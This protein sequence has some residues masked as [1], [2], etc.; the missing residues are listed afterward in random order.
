MWLHLALLLGFC[1]GHE[2]NSRLVMAPQPGL[3]TLY[4]LP[5]D[6]NIYGGITIFPYTQFFSGFVATTGLTSFTIEIAHSPGAFYLDDISVTPRGVSPASNVV[7]NPGFENAALSPWV[8]NQ[9]GTYISNF[10]VHSGSS[11]YKNSINTDGYILTQTFNTVP[12]TTYDFNFWLLGETAN[13]GQLARV[14]IRTDNSFAA[15]PYTLSLSPSSDSGYSHTDSITNV[16]MPVIVG[17]SLPGSQVVFSLDGSLIADGG[18][19]AAADGTFLYTLPH[20]NPGEN[21]VE[22]AVTQAYVV[23]PLSLKITYLPP[24]PINLLLDPSTDSG[25]IGDGITS[26]TTILL[27]GTTGRSTVVSLSDG[28]AIVSSTTSDPIT[29]QFSLSVLVTVGVHNFLASGSDDAG[30]SPSMNSPLVVTIIGTTSS[31]SSSTTSYTSS[32]SST[33]SSTS[34]TTSLASAA[35]TTILSGF[36]TTTSSPSQSSTSTMSPVVN[37]SSLSSESTSTVTSPS[38]TPGAGTSSTLASSLLATASSAPA[39]TVSEYPPWT[40]FGCVGSL[41]N[42]QEFT[43]IETSPLMNIQRCLDNCVGFALAGLHDE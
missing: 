23:A 26:F 2:L 17:L 11:S 28:V 18:V 19:T 33:T 10:G 16:A 32:A 42:F 13:P 9:P 35:T 25:V 22:A 41:G 12:S 3:V 30:N 27:V 36:S 31:S 29:G 7:I 34:S 6:G 1:L 37:S 4:E 15:P 20:L 21:I 14:R 40:F 38:F 39:S 43:P 5:A 8:S 24:L